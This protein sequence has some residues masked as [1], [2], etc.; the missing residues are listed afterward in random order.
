MQCI[1]CALSD[2]LVEFFPYRR[3]K[4]GYSPQCKVC[5]EKVC[6]RCKKPKLLEEFPRNAKGTFGVGYYCKICHELGVRASEAKDPEKTL[7]QKSRHHKAWRKSL[8]GVTYLEDHAEERAAYHAQYRLDN[9]D[10][11]IAKAAAYYQKNKEHHNTVAALWSKARPENLAAG[12][13][14]RRAR[15]KSASVNDLSAG[16][17][18]EIKSTAGFRC[19]YCGQKCAPGTLTLDHITP[20]GP[21]G[22]HTLW[23]ATVAC[24]SCNSK[25]HRKAPLSPVQPLLLTIAAPKPHK[26]RKG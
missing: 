2:P 21:D 18:A 24:R 15:K 12:Q 20:I 6:G 26:S 7:Q 5:Q 4:T 1:T 22:P 3:S 11:E 19:A 9:L 25:K 23:N 17:I 8:K 14:R 13:R 16:Q 10:E